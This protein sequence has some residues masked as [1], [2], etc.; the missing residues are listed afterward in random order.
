MKGYVE[1][2]QIYSYIIVGDWMMVIWLC[3]RSFLIIVTLIV[4]SM[5]LI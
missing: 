1:T 5:L 4:C 2:S 3:M